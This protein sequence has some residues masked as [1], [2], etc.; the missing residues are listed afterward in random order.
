MTKISKTMKADIIAEFF[1]EQGKRLTNLK[2]VDVSK[3]DE[4]ILKYNI[5]LEIQLEKRALNIE[6]EKNEK[7]QRQNAELERNRLRKEENSAKEKNIIQFW[8]SITTDQQQ[9]ICDKISLQANSD[10]SKLNDKTIRLTD[11]LEADCIKRGNRVERLAPNELR[12]NGIIINNGYLAE[13]ENLTISYVSDHIMCVFTRY[14]FVIEDINKML[15]QKQLPLSEKQIARI[16]R[17]RAQKC[18]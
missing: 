9:I 8:N 7:I 4:L 1:A 5:N 14:Q 11:I 12:I 17:I 10:N 3:L 13:K 6:K 16:A 15:S 2:K 18:K